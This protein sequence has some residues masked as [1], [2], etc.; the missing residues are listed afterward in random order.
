MAR[1][2][3]Q[4]E[5]LTTEMR[6]HFNKLDSIYEFGVKKHT[7][8]WCMAATAHKFFLSIKTVQNTLYSR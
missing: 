4:K 1:D 8:V 2:P 6:A 5:R 3:E 7:T